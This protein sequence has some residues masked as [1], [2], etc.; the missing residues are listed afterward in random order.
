MRLP[1]NISV[2]ISGGVITINQTRR[3]QVEVISL[4]RKDAMQLGILLVKEGEAK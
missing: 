3:G 4:T 1:K 2:S